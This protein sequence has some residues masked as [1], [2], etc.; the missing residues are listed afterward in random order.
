MDNTQPKPNVGDTKMAAGDR[1]N[2][3]HK[4]VDAQDVSLRDYFDMQVK[5]L[6]EMIEDAEK[7]HDEHQEE[8]TRA[9]D[10]RFRSQEKALATALAANEKR[11]DGMNEFRSTLSDQSKTF[12]NRLEHNSL[13]SS[14][15][16]KFDSVNKRFSELNG[17]IQNLQISDAVING[18]AS[19]TQVIISYLIGIAG[20]IFGILNIVAK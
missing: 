6:K 16:E 12:I 8:I 2:A 17:L 7:A 18:K 11:L 20:I 19:Q 1:I 3:T 10:E 15:N 9:L 14:T 5:F 4:Y 13:I